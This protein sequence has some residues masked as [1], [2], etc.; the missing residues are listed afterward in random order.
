MTR[1]YSTLEVKS[2]FEKFGLFMLDEDQYFSCKEK[3]DI[4]DLR[5]YKYSIS[6]DAFKTN[7]RTGQKRLFEFSTSNRFSLENIILWIKNERKTYS[8]VSGVF[9]RASD[10]NLILKCRNCLHEWNTSWNDMQTGKGC[11]PCSKKRVGLKKRISKDIVFKAFEDNCVRILNKS[12]YVLTEQKVDCE[13]MK[14]GFLW[15]TDYHHIRRGQACPKCKSS[16][17]E[18]RIQKFLDENNILYEIQKRFSEC[19]FNKPLPFDFYLPKY[20]MCIEYNGIQHYEDINYF[21]GEEA[22]KERRKR[23]NIKKSFCKKNG[24]ELISIKY[25]DFDKIETLLGNVLSNQE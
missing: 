10:R 1:K 15:K 7:I 5:G 20:N 14:C 13:C 18:K 24:I 4:K 12:D 11:P 3:V 16:L 21:G 22:L 9:T 8:F 2:E 25:L 19:K 6:F 17:G 23:D